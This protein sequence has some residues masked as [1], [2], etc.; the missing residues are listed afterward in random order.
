MQDKSPPTL[1]VLSVPG[2]GQLL[3]E[4]PAL[5]TPA[6]CMLLLESIVPDK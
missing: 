4:N 1:E 3:E 6:M 2:M 5:V